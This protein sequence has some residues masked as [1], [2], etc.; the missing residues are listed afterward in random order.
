MK[1]LPVSSSTGAVSSASSLEA[2]CIIVSLAML[3]VRVN[4]RDNNSNAKNTIG[5]WEIFFMVVVLR[6][7]N[8]FRQMF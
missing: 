5:E 6:G 7:A 8:F 2:D 4:E 3:S 1:W